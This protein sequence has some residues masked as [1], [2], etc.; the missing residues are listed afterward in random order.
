MSSI[1]CLSQ[2]LNMC[3]CAVKKL[4][5]QCCLVISILAIFWWSVSWELWC[6]TIFRHQQ[7]TQLSQ[8]VDN[9]TLS[10]QPPVY[11]CWNLSWGT[12]VI[13]Y[14]PRSSHTALSLDGI[15]WT[16]WLC[17][18]IICW[19][20]CVCRFRFWQWYSLLP[21]FLHVKF[22]LEAQELFAVFLSCPDINCFQ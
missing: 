7:K 19:A 11:C 18:S 2:A 12:P 17:L 1:C 10:F 9:C 8:N 14:Q 20:L 5:T 4:L 13:T 21:S 15:S 16:L 6:T 3:W 22:H